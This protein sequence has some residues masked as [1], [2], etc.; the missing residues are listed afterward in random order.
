MKRK[1]M[2]LLGVVCACSLMPVSA[3]TVALW[4]F[5]IENGSV[6]CAIDPR[7]DM[8][9]SS[10]SNIS[11]TIGWNLPPNADSNVTAA[12]DYMFA[13]VSRL[14]LRHYNKWGYIKC[15]SSA[16][17][18]T[19]LNTVTGGDFTV[20]GFFMWDELAAEGSKNPKI[21]CTA[22]SGTANKDGGWVLECF[23]K[24]TPDGTATEKTAAYFRLEGNGWNREFNDLSA[25]ET[26]SLTNGWN[27]FALVFRHDGSADSSTSDW[28]LYLNGV[29]K[30]TVNRRFTASTKGEFSA[31]VIGRHLTAGDVRAAFGYY[32]YWRV[33]D[34]ALSPSGFLNYDP[35]S[36]GGTMVPEEPPAE[37]AD[38]T[39]AYWKLNY[40]DG[41]L[42][43]RDYVG[44][45]HLGSVNPAAC[46]ATPAVNMMLPWNDC[47]FD[48][49][50]PNSTVEFPSGNDGSF[51]APPTKLSYIV[52]TNNAI[53]ATLDVTN[54]F[55]V[56]GWF[57]PQRR[58]GSE[59]SVQGWMFGNL[60]NQTSRGWAL[61]TEVYGS[62]KRRYLR[63]YATNYNGSR[64][65]LHATD[66]ASYRFCDVTDW[67]EEWR[68]VA[69]TYDPTGG[70]AGYGVWNLY[71]DGKPAG[72]VENVNAPAA[73]TKPSTSF[74]IGGTFNGSFAGLYDAIRVS[75]GV[76]SPKQFMCYGGEDAVAA[77]GVIATWP[78]NVTSG[79]GLGGA[80][81][82]GGYNLFGRS[83]DFP[84]GLFLTLGSDG[85]PAATIPNPDGSLAFDGDS[86]VAATNEGSVAFRGGYVGD[87]AW[88][89]TCDSAVI[90]VLKSE[91]GWTLEGYVRYD[92]TNGRAASTSFGSLLSFASDVNQNKV[93]YLLRGCYYN[94]GASHPTGA[95]YMYSDPFGTL[96]AETNVL[97]FVKNRWYH[98]AVCH[99]YYVDDSGGTPVKMSRM[100][101]YL[102]GNLEETVDTV[103]RASVQNFTW[104]VFGTNF[105]RARCFPGMV[106]NFR[107]SRG[108]LSPSE[109]L[110]A[111]P[112]AVE[113]ATTENATL[114]Y[115]PV[116]GGE[117]TPVDID[118]AFGLS[119]YSL[120]RQPESGATGSV[121]RARASV[122]NRDVA[123]ARRNDGSAYLSDGGYLCAD[124]VGKGLNLDRAWT[125][126][127][128]FRRESGAAPA[129][130]VLAGTYS[131]ETLDGWKLS[132]D[133]TGAVPVFRLKAVPKGCTPIA[134]GVIPNATGLSVNWDDWVHV[135]L[136]FIPTEGKGVWSLRVNGV[137]Y[138]SLENSW[139]NLALPA[140]SMLFSLGACSDANAASF[141][142][143]LD[144][145][146][147]S[148][149]L[150]A[151]V[152]L[153]Y[154]PLRG[155]SFTIR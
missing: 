24:Y 150:T 141:T 142:G 152:D 1:F 34:V 123:F 136:S 153:L 47:A 93:V 75:Q 92:E 13:P 17:L 56:E 10:I 135:A 14:C 137:F 16:P 20:E 71:L 117:D 78:L 129:N 72:T 58:T 127:G 139:R 109:F 100:R 98:F 143:N 39:V 145:W 130:R 15:D 5:E 148:S 61:G 144:M 110:N 41:K 29:S 128:W 108:V 31:L 131:D 35:E 50:P 51:L 124:Y 3:K 77:T 111:A 115:W 55:T 4:P 102:D 26:V 59:L 140:S 57:K 112:A 42:D 97:T 49:N 134:D 147:V 27:H 2:I 67:G 122:P 86:T 53:G 154:R 132:I 8:F 90:N 95:C 68:H 91:D 21:L 54:A 32:D 64:T 155:L 96:P 46:G 38:R 36:K 18:E 84:E 79:T 12:A 22:F 101:Y 28:T 116:D 23:N 52:V 33:S 138:G 11:Q 151:D 43:L 114:A 48:G 6:R 149:G 30:G 73:T 7:N 44:S 63:I 81:L 74:Y 69:L 66:A 85:M 94:G 119:G 125:A 45:A 118:T 107:L 113:P 99:S 106:N 88:L 133:D 80:N 105:N 60:A 83:T 40:A 19:A 120:Y 62:A 25:E 70:G 9:P 87:D 126:E 65:Y 103:A 121:A 82:E 146:R 76:L 104:L 89:A 37:P